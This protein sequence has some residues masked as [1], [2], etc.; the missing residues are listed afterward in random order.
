M[1]S[2]TTVGKRSGN[3]V[4]VHQRIDR[5][6]RRQLGTLLSDSQ[7]FPSSRDILHF[8]GNN[9][10]DGVKRKSPSVDEPW[11]YID[12]RKPLDV[13]LV[14]MIRDHITNLSRALSQNNEQR[15]AFEA[16]WLSHAIVDGLTPAH[17]FPLADKIE[18]LFGMAHHERLTVRQKNIIKGTGRRDTLSKNWEYWGSGGIFTSHFLFEFGVSATMVGRQYNMTVTND[19]LVDLQ[20]RGYEALF[21]EAIEEVVAMD[22]YEVFRAQGW[23]WRVARTVHG[24]LVPLLIKM[25]VLGWY[26]AV[27]LEE[28]RS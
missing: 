26:A 23:N 6:A 11:H 22:L 7:T 19:D 5:I 27:E 16:A 25:V 21:K 10:P 8:E 3:F 17:H 20:L 4:G 14:E 9:G 13:S 24:K 1:Y 12:P 18:D 28:G 15:A 2:G